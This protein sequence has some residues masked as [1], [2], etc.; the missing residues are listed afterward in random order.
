MSKKITDAEMTLINRIKACGGEALRDGAWFH[1]GGFAVCH[2][3]TIERMARK[4]LVRMDKI[5][6][7]VFA[8]PAI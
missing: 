4:G 6:K 7:S 5:G 2:K 1:A 3:S 8:V